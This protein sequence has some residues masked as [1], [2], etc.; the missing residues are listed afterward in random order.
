M[1]AP[2]FG[3]AA[4]KH[5]L[6]DLKDTMPGCFPREMRYMR[7]Q[8]P[9]YSLHKVQEMEDGGRPRLRDSINAS[10]FGVA[11]ISLKAFGGHTL[12]LPRPFSR[13]RPSVQ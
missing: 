11:G 6:T 4:K 5:G 1:Q 12:W 13:K 9:G 7:E 8:K 10:L 3:A 2:A